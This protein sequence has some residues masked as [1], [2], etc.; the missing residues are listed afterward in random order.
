[1]SDT[2]QDPVLGA[3]FPCHYADGGEYGHMAIRTTGNSDLYSYTAG[4]HHVHKETVWMSH[5]D[6]AEQLPDGFA[7]VATSEQVGS[8]PAPSAA[9]SQVTSIASLPGQGLQLPVVAISRFCTVS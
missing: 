5:V 1:M 8:E 4:D 6:R 2:P 9:T 3:D 7:P